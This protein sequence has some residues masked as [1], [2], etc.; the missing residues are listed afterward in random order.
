MLARK[1]PAKYGFDADEE[2][3]KIPEEE[4]RQNP[5]TEAKKKNT[6]LSR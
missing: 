3:F 5:A 2:I 6:L 4:S 1:P